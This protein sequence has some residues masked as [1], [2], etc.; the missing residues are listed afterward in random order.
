MTALTAAI[1]PSRTRDSVRLEL[2]AVSAGIKHNL[3]GREASTPSTL[4]VQLAEGRKNDGHATGVVERGRF[5]TM[6]I[7]HLKHS[8]PMDGVY[9]GDKVTTTARLRQENVPTATEAY[10]CWRFG[11]RG[12]ASSMDAGSTSHH[13]RLQPVRKAITIPPRATGSRQLSR[14]IAPSAEYLRF[15]VS[16]TGEGTIRRP[17]TGYCF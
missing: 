17:H 1:A 7:K 3:V 2:L 6:R 13:G 9:V 14:S 5:V 10:Q 11:R 12:P 16:D 8:I 15:G 4:Q